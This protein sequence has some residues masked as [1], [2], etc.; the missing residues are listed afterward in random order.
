MTRWNWTSPWRILFPI[1]TPPG[2]LGL[3]L[4]GCLCGLLAGLAISAL[5]Y[6]IDLARSLF[7]QPGLFA[8]E[9]VPSVP[10]GFWIA[11]VGALLVGLIYQFIK[12]RHRHSGMVHVVERLVH[13][14]GQMPSKNAWANLVGTVIAAGSGQLVGREGAA[15]HLG[16][17]G[18]SLIGKFLELPH[19]T[20]RALVGCGAAAGIAASFNTPL[21]G[22]IF[23]ME[24]IVMEYSV[25]GLAPTIIAAVSANAV[26]HVWLTAHPAL[27]VSVADIES[28]KQLPILLLIGSILGLCA[29]AYQQ[30][31]AW[32]TV[33]AQKSPVWLNMTCAGLV[34]GLFSIGLPLATADGFENIN[35]ALAGQ[36]S[37]PVSLGL[38]GIVLICSSLA[39]ASAM[40]GGIIMPSMLAGACMGS[41]LGHLSHIFAGTP[42]DQVALYALLGLGAMMGAVLQAPLTALIVILELSA[43]TEMVFAAMITVITAVLVCRA[44]S[45]NE[46]IVSLLIKKRGLDFRND[47]VSRSLR[48]LSVIPSMNRNFSVAGETITLEQARDVLRNKPDWILVRPEKALAFVIGASD[49]QHAVSSVAESIENGQDSDQDTSINLAKI[50]AD[51]RQCTAVHLRASLQE[52]IETLDSTGAEALFVERRHRDDPTMIYGILTRKAIDKAYRT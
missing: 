40:P 42:A 6:L 39:I 37:L 20:V 49:L 32:L 17:V 5:H 15:S 3:S 1:A 21:A 31:I 45:N 14:Q 30:A 24:V 18:G 25:L 16:A 36:F 2:V 27:S 50:P 26:A 23:T 19:S 22:V 10:A 48:R 44:T 33:R 8:N 51:R 9:L 46:S 11:L 7:Q 29:S 35:L 12:P 52:A 34:T 28:L 43:R 47:P 4:L 13:H 41:A 38:A